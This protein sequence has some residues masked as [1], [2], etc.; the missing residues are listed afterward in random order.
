MTGKQ[1]L[2]DSFSQGQ[3]LAVWILAAKLPKFEF[4][5]EFFGVDF[6]LFWE[7]APK[8]STENQP[9]NP[10][11]ICSEYSPRISAEPFS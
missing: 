1:H 6:L 10:H 7:M 11:E 2:K 9:Q 8:T 3:I 4:I 5:F